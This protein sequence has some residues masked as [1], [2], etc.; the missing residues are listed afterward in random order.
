MESTCL[1]IKRKLIWIVNCSGHKSKQ[2]AK[3]GTSI[4]WTFVKAFYSWQKDRLSFP[5]WVFFSSSV[6]CA[7]PALNTPHVHTYVRT[8]THTNILIAI[9]NLC[10]QPIRSSM[11]S[12]CT[13]FVRDR[14]CAKIQAIFIK[15]TLQTK[16]QDR[17]F[18]KHYIYLRIYIWLIHSEI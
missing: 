7:C 1:Q 10:F 17:I 18:L 12:P 13:L 2:A 11:L 15:S 3:S 4:K 6:H 14:M 5:C 9:V 8:H 16:K